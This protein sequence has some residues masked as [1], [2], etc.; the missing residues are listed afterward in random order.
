MNKYFRAVLANYAFFLINTVFLLII[1]S[2]AVRVLGE[3]FYGLWTILNAIMLFSGVGTLG[4]G[5]VVNKFASEK[6]K[7]AIAADII[8]S[9]GII[10]MLP[11][12][13]LGM[14]AIILLREWIASHINV[15][16]DLQ[17]QFRQALG[18]TALTIISSF[19]NFK[20]ALKTNCTSQC[21][22]LYVVCGRVLDSHFC[23][24]GSV[25]RENSHNGL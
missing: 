25:N 9:S 14:T 12:A 10:I 7:D 23:P 13:G 17:V 20:F 22:T 6:G 1:T 4:M 19:Y 15:S 16:P 5:V 8:I 24:L 2:I 18:F 21:S 11:M 3:E